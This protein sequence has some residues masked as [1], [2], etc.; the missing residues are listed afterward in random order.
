VG[1]ASSYTARMLKLTARHAKSA[2]LV[3]IIATLACSGCGLKGPLYRTGEDAHPVNEQNSSPVPRKKSPFSR[4]PA[5]QAQKQPKQEPKQD[6]A[7]GVP[8][9]APPADDSD[10]PAT[11]TPTPTAPPKP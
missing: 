3:G 10:S 6:S 5:P 4:I 9:D 7:S 8:S 11:S 2:L 1:L